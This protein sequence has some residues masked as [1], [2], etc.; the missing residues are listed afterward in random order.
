MSS[1]GLSLNKI[2]AAVII[3]LLAFLGWFYLST[4]EDGAPSRDARQFAKVKI[5][6][7]APVKI[8]ASPPTD[9]QSMPTAALHD[10]SKPP[11][12]KATAPLPDASPKARRQAEEKALRTQEQL[13]AAV[14]QQ[15]SAP[16]IKNSPETLNAETDNIAVL[17]S[18]L[19]A[20]GK[21]P[22]QSWRASA[23]LQTSSVGLP[24]TS[25]RQPPETEPSLA[26]W[27]SLLTMTIPLDFLADY[28]YA[29]CFRDAARDNALP[30]P[31]VLALAASFSNFD[32]QAALDN[33]HG[34]MGIAW[35][36]PAKRLGF[37]KQVELTADPCQNIQAGCRFLSGLYRKYSRNWVST[38]LAYRNQDTLGR[39]HPIFNSDLFFIERL[40]LKVA[41]VTDKPYTPKYPFHFWSFDDRKTALDFLLKIE[42]LASLNLWFGQK[43]FSYGIYILASDQAAARNLS[44]RIRQATGLSGMLESDLARRSA[45]KKASHPD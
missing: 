2:L 14:L 28:P 22:G 27:D 4:E 32:P 9:R 29:D 18:P 12:A 34:I 19:A 10:P 3:G 6:D 30:L 15:T 23:V 38:L 45:A 36:D 5:R 35:P 40:R 20:S 43:D 42:K 17:N 25:A 1:K 16:E 11:G 8:E 24:N 33:R 41:A 37:E 44:K 39:D 21:A 31:L 13:S 26:G 7:S